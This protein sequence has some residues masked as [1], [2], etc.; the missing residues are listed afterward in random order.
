MDNYWLDKTLSFKQILI[1]LKQVMKWDITYN[2]NYDTGSNIPAI[3]FMRG[4]KG[5]KTIVLICDNEVTVVHKGK[6]HSFPIE[7]GD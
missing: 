3:R 6:T 1:I 4:R 2:C 7:R 5:D